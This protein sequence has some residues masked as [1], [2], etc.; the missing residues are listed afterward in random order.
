MKY[1]LLLVML[2]SLK[3]SGQ[4]PVY[5]DSTVVAHSADSI[6]R[7]DALQYG[8][9][10]WD[11]ETGLL[12]NVEKQ[13][14]TVKVVMLVCDTVLN[15]PMGSSPNFKHNYEGQFFYYRQPPVYWQFGY[16]VREE[17]CCIN[18]NTSNNSIYQPVPYYT[19]IEYLDDK[20]QPLS[21]N[22]VV[23]QSKNL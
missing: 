15:R 21:K 9:I 22:I 13:T 1:I 10:Y 6:F 20:K 12:K 23:W 4:N 8:F 14:D 2:F 17:H 11:A 3:A 19:H 7:F 18:G 5:I 16:S